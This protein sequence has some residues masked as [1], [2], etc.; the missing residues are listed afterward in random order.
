MYDSICLIKQLLEQEVN[1]LERTFGGFLYYREVVSMLVQHISEA[2]AR[3][4]NL[5]ME[6]AE[7]NDKFRFT[8]SF[9]LAVL[10]ATFKAKR[11][12][13][14]GFKPTSHFRVYPHNVSKDFSARLYVPESEICRELLLKRVSEF[15]SAKTGARAFCRFM[16]HK[17]SDEE[18]YP[19]TIAIIVS[20]R[21]SS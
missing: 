14:R 16:P 20:T 19:L 12:K 6:I 5:Q 3:T 4:S 18:S 9:R 10:I 8:L 11:R 7:F 13:A 17:L 2:G 1:P 21:L 15:V